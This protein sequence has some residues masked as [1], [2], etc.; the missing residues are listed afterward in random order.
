MEEYSTDLFVIRDG[1]EENQ[2][3][4]VLGMRYRRERET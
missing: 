4:K 1:E 3:I 2:V